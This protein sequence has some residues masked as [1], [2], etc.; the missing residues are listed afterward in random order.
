[1]PRKN[2]IALSV[3]AMC[4]FS[5]PAQMDKRVQRRDPATAFDGL[6]KEQLALED[7]LKGLIS[8]G[9]R[10]LK[11]GDASFAIVQYLSALELVH[12][13]P[14]LAKW[15]DYV[16]QKLGTGYIQGNRP[17]NAIRI[18]SRLLEE[19]THHCESET[20]AVSNCADAQYGLG[21][22]KIR[23]GD[24]TGALASLREAEAN[25]AKAEKLNDSHQ[26]AM[27]QVKNEAQTKVW[28]AVALSKVGKT[29]DAIA[30]AEAALPQLAR[31]QSD[32]SMLAAIRDDAA[33]SLRDAQALLDYLKPIQ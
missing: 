29:A 31:V 19:R 16:L 26:F 8:R 14:L 27:M 10:E 21:E 5:M 25:Y 11:S 20:A 24:F 15:Q 6:S 33:R 30:T 12:Q 22:G 17:Q 9:D 28:I 1:M 13:Q 7:Q 4:S 2:L 3:L 23:A 18:F 32:E